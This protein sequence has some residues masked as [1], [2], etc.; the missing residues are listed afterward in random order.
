MNDEASGALARVARG[1][2]GTEVIDRLAALSGSDFASVR[3][4]VVRRRIPLLQLDTGRK[5]RLDFKDP[6]Q[7]L[8]GLRPAQLSF[9]CSVQQVRPIEMRKSNLLHVGDD[10]FVR[11]L[12]IMLARKAEVVPRRM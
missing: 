3:L 10:L 5:I 8:A 4:E 7:G 6:G 9:R 12:V 1:I 11:P 2:G